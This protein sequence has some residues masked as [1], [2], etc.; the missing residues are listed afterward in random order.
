[1]CDRVGMNVTF[2]LQKITE[3]T[4]FATKTKIS[5]YRIQNETGKYGTA[6]KSMMV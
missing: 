1:M 3:S 2:F 6:I 5:T 4:L